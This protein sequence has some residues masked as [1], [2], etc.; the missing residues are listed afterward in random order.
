MTENQR[1]VAGQNP[2][3][4]LPIRYVPPIASEHW[5]APGTVV[6]GINASSGEPPAD[7]D[8]PETAA[9]VVEASDLENFSEI[10]YMPGYEGATHLSNNGLVVDGACGQ[11]CSGSSCSRPVTSKEERTHNFSQDLYRL[12]PNSLTGPHSI[13]DPR[14]YGF[15]DRPGIVNR[16]LGRVEYDYRDIDRLRIPHFLSRNQLDQTVLN[17]P[18]G[19]DVNVNVFAVRNHTD[20]VL[21]QRVEMQTAW[22]GRRESDRLQ[23]K[24]YPI[25]TN[26]QFVSRG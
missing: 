20:S 26:G 12:T 10:F 19:G 15:A 3:T 22:L 7:V 17:N 25:N 13:Y 23:R 11:Y 1:L 21:E 24:L 14:H 6:S 5:R 18:S 8:A 16:L 4:L 2:K 9:I